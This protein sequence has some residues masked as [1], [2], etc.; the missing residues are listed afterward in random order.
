MKRSLSAVVLGITLAGC[1]YVS[2]PMQEG[3]Q[4]YGAGQY[5]FAIE[6]FGREIHLRPSSADAYNNRAIAKVRAGELNGAVLDYNRAI[7]L[8]PND[9]DLYYNRANALVAA[10]DF[11]QAIGD[12]SQA[13]TLNPA[14]AKA[15]FNRGSV[16]ALAGQR[17]LAMADWRRAIDL[18]PD[19]WAKSS[20]RRSAGLETPIAASIGPDVLQAPATAAT[21]IAPAPPAGTVTD[22][23]PLP[24]QAPGAVVSVPAAS[25]TGVAS[26]PAASPRP[27]DARALV[28]RGVLRELD[29][30]HAGAM[31]DLNAALAVEPDPARRDAIVNIL[32]RLDTAR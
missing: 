3:L 22:A 14:Y 12:F 18:E 25:A 5:L 6:A 23:L 13:V 19:P 21:R 24:H 16:R 27:S 15:Y 7:E 17:D 1:S 9:P 20:M 31:E 2:S 32:R 30:D 10:G 11:T 4:Y 29:G 26:S 28:S 8:S